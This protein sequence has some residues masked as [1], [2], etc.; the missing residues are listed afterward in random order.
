MIL[1]A[2]K[3]SVNFQ[4]I[5]NHVFDMANCL[6]TI[7]DI[8]FS[9]IQQELLAT[10]GLYHTFSIHPERPWNAKL[11]DI[12]Y[13]RKEEFVVLCNAK[14]KYGCCITVERNVEISTVP[15]LPETDIKSFPG[16]IHQSVRGV[17]LCQAED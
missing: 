7:P 9:S 13:V 16:G 1:I 4:I 14:D 10:D 3:P 17:Y 8:S 11:F 5:A 15:A 2:W 6:R 12:G